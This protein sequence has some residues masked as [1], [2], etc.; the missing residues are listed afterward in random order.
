MNVQVPQILLA[1]LAA[2]AL[3]APQAEGRVVVGGVTNPGNRNIVHPGIYLPGGNIPVSRP[4]PPPHHRHMQPPRPQ[5]RHL[6]P[7]PP[8]PKVKSPDRYT[9][10]GYL[11]PSTKAPHR[12]Q[13][14]PLQP[15]R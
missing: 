2:I 7:P 9:P 12:V 14:G 4:A 10:D 11:K 3:A 6:P 5:R 1:A 8:R 15:H 13:D